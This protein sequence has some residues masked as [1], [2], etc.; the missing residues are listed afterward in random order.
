MKAEAI[1]TGG[2]SAI[3]PMP[4]PIRIGIRVNELAEPLDWLEIEA[5][6]QAALDRLRESLNRY[7]S[8]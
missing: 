3:D 8:S 4:S 2:I 5:N 7:E 1:L 6:V